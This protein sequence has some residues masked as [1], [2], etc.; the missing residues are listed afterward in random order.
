M[1]FLQTPTSHMNHST[2]P[3][4]LNFS[5]FLLGIF[6][7]VT[8]ILILAIILLIYLFRDQI[9]QKVKLQS[10]KTEYF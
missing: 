9:S 2:E 5:D 4:G 1:N 10:R 6:V 8:L 7:T 3:S